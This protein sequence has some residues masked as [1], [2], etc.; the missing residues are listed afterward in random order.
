MS[1]QFKQFHIA[2][3]QCAMKVG[4]DGVLLGAWAEIHDARRI[5]DIGTG[6]GLIAIMAAQRASRAEVVGIDIDED[7]TKQAT[8]NAVSSPFANRLSIRHADIT[9]YQAAPF[10][11][12]LSNPPYHTETLPSPDNRRAAA[13]HAHGLTLPS[14]ITHATRLLA[15]GGM[16]HLIIPVAAQNIVSAAAIAQGLHLS[17]LTQVHTTAQKPPRRLLMSWQKTIDANHVSLLPSI[18]TSKLILTSTD[19]KRTPE[20]EALTSEFYIK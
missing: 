4:T 3:D 19:G 1:F 15:P 8:E 20:H 7:S 16:F 18:R 9:E 17:R 6:C 11:H 14:L 12:I 13:R 5:L 2:D 10:D